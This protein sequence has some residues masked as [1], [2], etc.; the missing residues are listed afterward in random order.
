[1]IGHKQPDDHG[2]SGSLVEFIVT[3]IFEG[4]IG[5]AFAMLRFVGHAVAVMLTSVFHF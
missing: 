5:F 4:G 1:M 2:E 3:F